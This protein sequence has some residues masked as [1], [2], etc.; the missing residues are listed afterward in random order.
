MKKN[1]KKTKL[2]KVCKTGG[3]KTKIMTNGHRVEQVREFMYLGSMV[4]E[5]CKCQVKC[6]TAIEK[7][8]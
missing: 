2:V 7:E 3:K 4:T 8:A 5:D 1:I 6:Q